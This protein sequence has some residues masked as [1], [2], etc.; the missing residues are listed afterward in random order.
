[1]YYQLINFIND[2]RAVAK[3]LISQL[4]R[5]YKSSRCYASS[6]SCIKLVNM[7]YTDS[8]KE[9]LNL[10]KQKGTLSVDEAV[11]HTRLAK[12]TLREHFLQLER[13]GCIRREYIRSGPGRP[14]LQYQITVKGNR[15][16]Q[17]PVIPVCTYLLHVP[18]VDSSS[19]TGKEQTP[20]PV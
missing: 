18:D 9:L 3:V 20:L 4:S 16:F 10:I 2:R 11:Y 15:L 1:M 7:M 13:D 19:N 12:T 6:G 17:Y 8:K 14:S 5:F